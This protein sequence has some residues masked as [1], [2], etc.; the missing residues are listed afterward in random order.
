VANY[1]RFISHAAIEDTF[2][3]NTSRFMMHSETEKARLHSSLH[4]T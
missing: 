1:G 2:I 3:V 4:E